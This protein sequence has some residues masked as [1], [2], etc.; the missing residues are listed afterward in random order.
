MSPA[1]AGAAPRRSYAEV[2]SKHAPCEL[3]RH[4]L[5]S[6]T[7]EQ[8]RVP[9]TCTGRP[10]CFCGLCAGRWHA[11]VFGSHRSYVHRSVWTHQVCLFGRSAQMAAKRSSSDTTSR[12]QQ[13]TRQAA[14][15]STSWRGCRRGR[16]QLQRKPRGRQK[17]GRV[18]SPLTMNRQQHQPAGPAGPEMLRRPVCPRRPQLRLL[19]AAP[20]ALASP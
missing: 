17:A 4:A 2:C 3:Q 15:R 12:R 6:N 7:Q 19:A 18:A 16:R 1:A 14:S 13:C 10:T 9:Y 20:V 11:F 8:P 5:S